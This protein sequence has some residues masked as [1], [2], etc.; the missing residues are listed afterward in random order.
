MVK[1]YLKVAFRSILKS[2]VFSIVNVLGLA[3]GIAAFLLIVQYVNFELSYDRFIP[4]SENIYRVTLEQYLNNEMMTES[5]ENYPGVGP[6]LLEEV[7]EVAGYARLYNMG[8]KNNLVI[9]Y[10]DAPNGPVMYKHRHFL[11]ADSAFLPMFGYEMVKGDATTALAEPL[12]AVISEEYARMYF[13]EEE[14]IGK[15]LHLQ[16]DD[17][18]NEL[19]K[20]TG[21]FKSLPANTHLKF[22][23]LFSYETLYSRGD[24]AP[25]RYN[26]SWQRKDMYTYVKL[27]PGT[28]P[29]VVAQKL[30]GLIRKYSPG[31]VEANREDVLKLQPITDIHL[32]SKL[33]DEAEANGNGRNV[34]ALALIAFFILLIA[35]VNYVNLS[36]A[37]AMERANEVG[38]RKALGAF[39]GQLMRQFLMESAIVNF[40][41]LLCSFIIIALV[42][43]LFNRMSGLS[44]SFFQLFEG[45]FML[46]CLLIW[47]VGTLLSGLYPAF[48]LSSFRP[49][50]V[51]K[52]K[53][54]NSGRGALLRK[55]LVVFQ[56]IASV[57]LISGTIIVYNQLS[58][59]RSMDIGME[60]DQVLVVERPGV[61]PRD[62]QAFSSN[63][64]V[65]REQLGQNPAIQG[66]STSITIPGKKREYKAGVKRYGSP[67]DDAVTLRMNSMDYNFIDV[68]GMELLAGRTFSEQYPNDPDTSVIITRSAV[69]LLGFEKPEDAIGQTLVVPGYDWSAIVVGVV[70]DYHQESLQKAQ[71][72]IIFYCTLYGG[73]FY[74]MKVSTTNLDET[75]KHVEASWEKAFPGNPFSY[76]FLDDYFNRQYENEQKFGNLFASFSVLAIIVGCL[77]LFGLSA[78]TARQKTKEIG[79]RKVLGSSVNSIFFLLSKDFIKLIVIAIIIAVPLTYYG[80]T[81]WLNGFAYRDNIALGTF[82]V[83]GAAVILSALITV[84]FQTVKAARVNPVDSLRYE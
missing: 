83:A 76:F 66:V 75:I 36:T 42:M 55:S 16:D 6:A 17:F 9:T 18:N 24:W 35:W 1:N 41:A 65:F 62:R 27:N 69:K 13:G 54:R 64:D 28:A 5:A 47:V 77:G 48:F 49:V 34:Y 67:D 44:L 73:E 84:S 19:C 60:I 72:P 30:P 33:A 10:E 38:V 53:L 46:C 59:M 21:V 23:V 12:S 37:K 51:L 8:Y 57:A 11:Y 61:A 56:F 15:M 68:F 40:A 52:G 39:K 63:I 2:K 78:F 79:I 43:P 81:Q 26:E 7:P 58:Y 29:D 4:Q 82:I 32:Y 3:I 71:D 14:P 20:V 25:A 31:L 74:S 50:S 70:N 22:D 45:W 80:M